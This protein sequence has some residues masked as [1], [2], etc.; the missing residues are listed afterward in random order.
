LQFRPDAL[1]KE[2]GQKEWQHPD[3]MTLRYAEI[4]GL[5]CDGRLSGLMRPLFHF[6]TEAFGGHIRFIEDGSSEIAATREQ[7]WDEKIAQDAAYF[8]G[9]ARERQE[10]MRLEEQK[11]APVYEF[12]ARCE[13][14]REACKSPEHRDRRCMVCCG[15]I[16]DR[17]N[18]YCSNCLDLPFRKK[19]EEALG[20]SVV[21]AGEEGWT[22]ER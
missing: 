1:E 14:E 20:R 3:P 18:R 5:R 2:E 22:R 16:G 17:S 4:G 6:G 8:N 15:G 9:L 7:S 12:C 21:Y 13:A 11:R 10:V 19:R